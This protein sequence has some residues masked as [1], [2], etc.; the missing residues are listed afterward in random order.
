MTRSPKPH[1][2]NCGVSA[3]VPCHL[4]ALLTHNRILMS[5]TA[6]W[7][8]SL[9][10]VPVHHPRERK[11]GPL[12]NSRPPD[13]PHHSFPWPHVSSTNAKNLW[14]ST[15][16][17]AQVLSFFWIISEFPVIRKSK[18]T[19]PQRIV[20]DSVSFYLRNLRHDG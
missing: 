11:K 4:L 7:S 19:C 8:P 20:C 3:V 1:T 5:L 9:T 13:F 10:P 6:L 15:L 2:A 18:T 12:E 17:A 16:R 14:P